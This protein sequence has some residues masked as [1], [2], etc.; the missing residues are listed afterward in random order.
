MM[1]K[2]DFFLFHYGLLY[3]TE[4]SSLCYTKGLAYPFYIKKIA[5]EFSVRNLISFLHQHHSSLYIFLVYL[6]MSLHSSVVYI[7]PCS[8]II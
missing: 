4:Y 8:S 3:N 6:S 1:I 7:L 2:P 5:S